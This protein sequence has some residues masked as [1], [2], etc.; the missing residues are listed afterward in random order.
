M[1]A[2]ILTAV[3]GL[4]ALV[5]LGAFTPVTVWAVA[6]GLLAALA[7]YELLHA[8]APRVTLGQYACACVGCFALN[9]GA[10]YGTG[11]VYDGAVLFLLTAYAGV[12]LMRSLKTPRPLCA[13]DMALLLTAGGVLPLLFSSLVSLRRLSFGWETLFLPLV[14]AFGTDIFAFF[15]GSAFGGKKLC[16]VISPHKTVAGA[17]GGLLGAVGCVLLYGLLIQ[18]LGGTVRQGVLAAYACLGSAAAQLGDLTFSAVKRTCGI[19]DYSKLLP[20]HGGILDRFDSVLF[21]APLM[22]ILLFLWPVF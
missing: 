9:I 20:G 18:A 12:E 17:V 16:P 6:V 22:E 11:A 3:V 10:A 4:P 19:K 8:A 13:G 5:L 7:S 21:T 2:R 1:K 14:I 15:A